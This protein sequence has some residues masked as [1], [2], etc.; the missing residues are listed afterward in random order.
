[1]LFIQPI[2]QRLVMAI[3]EWC[4]LVSAHRW[5]SLY[6]FYCINYLLDTHELLQI[7]KITYVYLGKYSSSVK[8]QPERLQYSFVTSRITKLRKY[9]NFRRGS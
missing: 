1:M 7:E 9:N 3:G 2:S 8:N 6:V 4:Y 5:I